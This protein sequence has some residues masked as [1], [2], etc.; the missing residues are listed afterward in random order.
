MATTPV[1]L[2]GES[3]GQRSLAGYSHRVAKSRTRLRGSFPILVLSVFS[4]DFAV[5][6]SKVFWIFYYI[7]I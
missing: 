3:H 5:L 7:I 2:P 6:F 4:V 1:F